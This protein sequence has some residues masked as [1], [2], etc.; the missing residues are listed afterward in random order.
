MAGTI[1][2]I[3]TLPFIMAE[4]VLLGLIAAVFGPV[5][6][7]MGSARAKKALFAAGLVVT[8]GV[9]TVGVL[10]TPSEFRGASQGPAVQQAI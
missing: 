2:T 9:M 10:Y 7:I 5:A 3:I 6:W 1:K 4:A 8:V